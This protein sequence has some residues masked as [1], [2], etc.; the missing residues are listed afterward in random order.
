METLKLGKITSAAGIRGEMRIYPYVED[1]R[2]F[3]EIA[4]IRV[5]GQEYPLQS[6]R[7]H[8]GMV[9]VKLGGVEDRNA[10]ERLRG[11][12]LCL[13]DADDWHL[14]EDTYLIRDLIGLS[15]CTRDGASVGTVTDVIQNPGHDLY[16]ICDEE[17]VKFLLPAVKEFVLDIDLTDG[18]ITVELIEGMK[19]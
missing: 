8:K 9:I 16:E 3:E 12:E 18:R 2:A 6:S 17:G 5:G 19:G 14:P 15:V 11:L 13:C 10:A 7:G 4:S 1:L